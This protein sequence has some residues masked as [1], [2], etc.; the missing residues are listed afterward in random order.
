VEKKVKYK[1]LVG[2]IHTK[3]TNK[4]N[5]QSNQVI[6]TKEEAVVVKESQS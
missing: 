6:K 1:T 2:H 3:Q 4:Q 5:H